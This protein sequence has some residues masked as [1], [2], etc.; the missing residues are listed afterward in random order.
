MTI[1]VLA[2][3]PFASRSLFNPLPGFI[4]QLAPVTLAPG[5]I[6]FIK[7]WRKYR[8]GEY[9]HL[10]AQE[11]EKLFLGTEEEKQRAWLRSLIEL[12][13]K[14][15]SEGVNMVWIRFS[16]ESELATYRPRG[17][18]LSGI[19]KLMKLD[20]SLAGVGKRRRDRWER[21]KA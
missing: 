17:T 10:R 5:D 2:E 19:L 8:R 13:I 16:S 7:L 21:A 14:Q 6:V 4:D 11:K 9:G 20:P 18:W 12:E 3:Q 15:P 1:Y